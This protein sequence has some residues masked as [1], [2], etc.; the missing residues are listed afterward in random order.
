MLNSA[1][2]R[3]VSL[4]RVPLKV[5]VITALASW[6]LQIYAILEGQPLWFIVVLTLLP[7]LPLI[8]FEGLWKFQHYHW[9][10]VF[11][12]VTALQVGHMAEHTVQVVQLGVLN[13]TLACPPPETATGNFATQAIIPD[14]NGQ[15][16]LD[17]N[18]NEIVG[19]T[20]CGVIGVFDFETVHLIWDT[21]VWVG[22]LWLL[23]KFPRNFWLWIAM[24]AASVHEVEHLFLGYI[25]FVETG[26]PYGY[27][28]Q[29]W[30]TFVNGNIVTARPVGIETTPA[31]FYDAGGK[32][33][34]LGRNGM[35]ESLIGSRDAF[36]PRPYLHFGYNMLVVIPTVI[37]F[38]V[39]ARKVYDQ[40]LAKA[41]PQ[42]SEDQLIQTTPRLERL[43][44]EPGS[45]I[46][47]QGD[48]ADRFYILTKGQVE[49][50]REQPDGQEIVVSRLGAGQYFGEIGLLHGGKRVATV[51]AADDV[52]VMALDRNT[53]GDLMEESELSRGEVDRLVRQRVGQLQA[54]QTRG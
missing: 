48:P 45:V 17:A 21:L 25:F 15:P 27:P 3:F 6:A 46:V 37:A 50:L 34:I 31:T 12:V 52:E 9:I 29:M 19:P 7:W 1:F 38:F 30:E 14:A 13:G 32:A 42:L 36:L 23:T 5:V 8:L 47:R 54:M 22:A 40:H 11:A 24:I 20:A 35:V 41:L 26:T 44:Y 33:G 43:T 49:V 18:G 28:R 39:Q 51:R 53:F 4:R 16:A 10:A 2:G